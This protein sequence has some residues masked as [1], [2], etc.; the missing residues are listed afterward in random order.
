MELTGLQADSEITQ[1]LDFLPR[2]TAPMAICRRRPGG[3]ANSLLRQ[4]RVMEMVLAGHSSKNIA[5]DISLSQRTVVLR[6]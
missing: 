2:R 3:S 5:A 1:L 4:R 6:S